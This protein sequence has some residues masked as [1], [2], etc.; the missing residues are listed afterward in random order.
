M[1]KSRKRELRKL[2]QRKARKEAQRENVLLILSE[3]ERLVAG[4]DRVVK[5]DV[6]P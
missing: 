3:G 6:V 4:H 2:R 1:K 5:W